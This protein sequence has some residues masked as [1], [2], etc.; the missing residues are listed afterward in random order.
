MTF[1]LREDKKKKKAKKCINSDSE[2]VRVFN[3]KISPETNPILWD[4]GLL[5][6]IA[7]VHG[8]IL[9]LIH[10]TVAFIKHC[11]MPSIWNT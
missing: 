3:L 11:C 4:K 6:N 5:W 10:T 1:P 2:L 8:E 9:G 7:R